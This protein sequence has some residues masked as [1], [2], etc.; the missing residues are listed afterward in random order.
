M[1]TEAKVKK[2]KTSS[3]SQT[4]KKKELLTISQGLAYLNSKETKVWHTIS[5]N[6]ENIA[7]LVHQTNEQH[8]KL[9]EDL[10]T[11]DEHGNAVRSEQN[12]I[13]FGD[14]L[15]EAN[16]IW[17]TTLDEE[18]TFDLHPINLEDI[19]DYGLDANIMKPLMGTLITE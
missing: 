3:L 18:V 11:K 1:S 19:K 2:M 17:E 8:K 7:T 4:M 13:D 16:K 5:Q 10:A 15:P 6:L 9:V 12:Q 14:N